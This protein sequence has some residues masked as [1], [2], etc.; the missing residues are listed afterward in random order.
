V[1]Q[2]ECRGKGQ[3]EAHCS[4]RFTISIVSIVIVHYNILHLRSTSKNLPWSIVGYKCKAHLERHC[5]FTR[6]GTIAATAVQ[7]LPSSVTASVSFA[8]SSGVHLPERASGVHLPERA[9]VWSTRPT[10]NQRSNFGPSLP[11]CVTA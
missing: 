8:S 3:G 9:L 10:R 1:L 4:S 6:P 5:V 11:N 2:D 7:S